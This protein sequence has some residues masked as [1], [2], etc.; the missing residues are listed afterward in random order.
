M[1][2]VEGATVLGG[3]GDAM[4][5][6]KQNLGFDMRGPTLINETWP[7]LSNLLIENIFHFTLTSAAWQT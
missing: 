1:L 6:V 4:I 7:R 2:E 3:G 5:E